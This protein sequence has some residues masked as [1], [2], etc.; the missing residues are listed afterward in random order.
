MP[1][2]VGKMIL[3]GIL[4]AVIY[5]A[6][7][8][9]LFEIL[10]M[11]NLMTFSLS[12]KITIIIL[13]IVGT[14]F[15]MLSHAYPKDTSA[16]RI[17]AFISTIYSG[18]YLFYI[19]GGFT[20]GVQLGT[21]S[22]SLPTLQ[23][24]LGLQ[25]FAWLLLGSSG[26]RALQYLIEAI[27]LRKGK[28]YNL[29]LKKQFRLSKIFKFFGILASLAIFGYLG[30]IAYSATQLNFGI[31]DTFDIGYDNAGTPNPA[32]DSVNVT[33]TFDVSN[34]G[35]YAIYDVYIDLEIYV[36]ESTNV[37]LPIGEK[38]GGSTG[39]YYGTFHS[40]STYP[41]QNITADISNT[42]IIPL[43]FNDATLRYDI[44]FNTLYAAILIDLEISINVPWTHLI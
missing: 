38:I 35:L 43:I 28:E 16:N 13:G 41:N 40:F 10:S 29:R 12:F 2:Q 36:Q 23:V 37:T 18:I 3:Y 7:P 15:S 33:M 6:G 27:E 20:P 14:V 32:D 31:H 24:L 30:S 11:M 8:L 44:S 42:Y 39:N 22:I 19:F 5:I 4:H 9:I 25:F 26:I 34:M 17:I 1:I 21:Y